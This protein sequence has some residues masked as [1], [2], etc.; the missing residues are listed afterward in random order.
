[1]KRTF[2]RK[3]DLAWNT[4]CMPLPLLV[5]YDLVSM[6]YPYLPSK[7]KKKQ[8]SGVTPTSHQQPPGFSWTP[9]SVGNRFKDAMTNSIP[10]NWAISTSRDEMQK[11][12]RS[13]RKVWSQLGLM[14]RIVMGLQFVC[15]VFVCFSS[16]ILYGEDWHK[17]RM[18][19]GF[20]G[21]SASNWNDV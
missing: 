2:A 6:H 7:Q 15:F 9:G 11:A 20:I 5:V 19:S 8:T 1:M 14:D 17:F 13:G 18:D 21:S 16:K 4:L 3:S 10:L 12:G